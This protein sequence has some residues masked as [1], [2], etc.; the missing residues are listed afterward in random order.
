[1]DKAGYR[2]E[3]DLWSGCFESQARCLYRTRASVSELQ[4]RYGGSGSRVRAHATQPFNHGP[5]HCAG[6]AVILFGD[7]GP[8]NHRPANAA[9]TAAAVRKAGAIEIP[10]GP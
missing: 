3:D 1:M 8:S 7:F 9:I 6:Q 5:H 2:E 4:Q 10:E